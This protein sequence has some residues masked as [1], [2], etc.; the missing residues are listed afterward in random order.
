[1]FSPQARAA[2]KTPEPHARA[3]DCGNDTSGA[4]DLSL[5]LEVKWTPVETHG[6]HGAASEA[7]SSGECDLRIPSPHGIEEH[8]TGKRRVHLFGAVRGFV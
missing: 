2:T 3:P 8:G 6:L 7:L 5:L 1:M 4:L